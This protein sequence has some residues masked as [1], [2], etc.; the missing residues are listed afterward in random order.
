M[1]LVAEAAA[2]ER[3]DRVVRVTAAG[4]SGSAAARS[5]PRT[6]SKP[7]VARRAMPVGTP[8]SRPSGIG[9]RPSCHTAA[10]AA[11]G[12][13]EV[14][15]EPGGRGR[16]RRAPGRGRRR[17]LRRRPGARRT[18]SCAAC[19]RGDRSASRTSITTSSPSTSPA[20]S[21][22]VVSPLIPPP[23][24][25]TRLTPASTRSASAA[26]TAGS[27]FIDA[28]RRNTRPVILGATAG[29][30]VEVVEHLEV[31]GDEAARADQQPVGVLRRPQLVDDLEHVGA[32]PRLGRAS[33]PTATRRT[34]A[35]TVPV[36]R[37]QRPRRRSRAARRGMGR[38]RRG[39][40]GAA[41][42][43]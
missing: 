21:K 35:P 2:D 19:R 29:L 5:L 6:D 36:R 41:S 26:I 33:R 37:R 8:S 16:C 28:V 31:I 11:V 22:A 18:A 38:R 7:V 20:S 1:D 15:V 9:C 34:T 40:G 3:A 24:T 10:V 17:R 12:D 13:V 42:G 39:L 23:T 25:R 27:S 32:D 30:D 43:P 4:S 14:E